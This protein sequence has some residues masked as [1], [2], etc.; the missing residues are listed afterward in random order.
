MYYL[1][2]SEESLPHTFFTFTTQKFYEAQ[3]TIREC[4]R[5]I[6][7]CSVFSTLL[8]LQ[9]LHPHLYTE[10]DILQFNKFSCRIFH[11][12]YHRG[13]DKIWMYSM[14]TFQYTKNIY[15]CKT[16][17]LNKFFPM[18]HIHNQQLTLVVY[19]WINLTIVEH[20]KILI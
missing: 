17:L 1:I 16:R 2:L 9:Y 13:E 6:N 10:L 19:K 7:F 12:Y 11:V 14:T 8:I 20:V 3:S 5:Q 15:Y 4:I 18:N